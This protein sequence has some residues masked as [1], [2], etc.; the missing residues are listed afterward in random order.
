MRPASSRS[1]E[2]YGNHAVK[3]DRR[4]RQ[5]SAY[6]LSSQTFGHPSEGF[7]LYAIHE[8]CDTRVLYG[9]MP[10]S[11]SATRKG[12]EKYSEFSDYLE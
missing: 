1:L 6:R 8:F 11:F 7:S 2:P 4:P 5:N 12:G 9:V 10:K 3:I